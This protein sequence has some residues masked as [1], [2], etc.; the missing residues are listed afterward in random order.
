MLPG[1]DLSADDLKVFIQE[2]DGLLELLDEDIIRLEQ[3]ATNE[4]LLQE[5]FRA[6]HTLKGSSGMIG[7]QAMADLTHKME[8]LLDRVR[9]GTLAV[10]P[11]LVDALLM[12]LD[13]LKELR[14]DLAAGQETSLDVAPIVAALQAAAEGDGPTEAASDAPSLDALVADPAIA[15][16]IEASTAAGVPL[17]RV[18]I[19]LAPDTEWASVRS[20]QVLNELSARGELIIS[21]PTM[22]DIEEERA[23]H[24]LEALL[25]TAT[26]TDDIEGA[27]GAVSDVASVTLSPWDGPRE[28]AP[29]APTPLADAKAA[30]KPEARA[31]D[32]GREGGPRVEALSQTVR[33]DVER[34][35]A[36]MNMVGELVIDR[37]RFAQVSRSLQSRYKEDEQ[38]RI[39]NETSLHISKV[40]D[41]LQ[42]S[43]MAVRM[44]PVG[45]LFSKF[46]RLVRDLARSMGKPVSFVVEGEGT[47]IDRSVIEE[48]KDPLVHLIRNAVDHGIE[49]PEDRKAAGKPETATVRL[50]ALHGQ[51]QILITLTDDGQGI[52]AT[53][54]REAAI[55]KGVVTAEAAARLSDQEAVE[56][57]FAPGF[58]TAKQTTE[59]SGR[60]VGMDIVRSKIEEL[61]GSVEVSTRPGEGTTFLLRLPLTLA[62]VRGLLVESGGTVY[63]IPLAYV[64]EILRMET[65]ELHSV[66]G[67]PA[68]RRRDDA[69]SVL[70]LSDVLLGGERPDGSSEP[71]EY[72]IVVRTGESDADRPVAIT[73][74]ALI[75]QQ[76]IVVKSLSGYLGRA[77]GIAG[78]SI[79]GDGQ[80]ALIVDV[81]SL[82]KAAQSAASA[83]QPLK[84]ERPERMAS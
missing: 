18:H 68:M 58:S 65:D 52:D 84:F 32:G 64:Q 30:S 24:T 28:A 46:P 67:R 59:V 11:G 56:L 49:S 20:F 39:L 41:E 77:R 34:L 44:L 60:G 23:S 15:A 36:L 33:I 4:E 54:I 81:P 76:E 5:I 13:G 82:M 2:V 73:V 83:A 57:I 12:S 9:K 43:M 3:E 70:N 6:A 74:D 53:K 50:A 79:L 62:T 51:G 25:A 61:S 29:A 63:A 55:N 8:D 27:V 40:I 66:G 35:D 69:M 22:Q 26:A 47:E 17:L 42:Q 16:R 21:A 1:I 48:I 72:V 10:T 19:E 31:A 14:D 75:D 45:V 78:A 71:S 38:V 80:V 37:T 7:Y